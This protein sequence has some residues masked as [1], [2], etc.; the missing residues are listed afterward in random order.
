MSR[1]HSCL[2]AFALIATASTAAT[3]EDDYRLPYGCGDLVVI[4]RVRTLGYTDLSG[5]DDLLGHGRF[6]VEVRIKRVVRGTESR[7]SLRAH[8]IAHGQLVANRD[9]LIVLT[10]EK[11]GQYVLSTAAL[12]RGSAFRRLADKCT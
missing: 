11:E 4:G 12:A 5:P 2:A 9:F 1:I 8:R 10:P 6:D 3:E 7:R